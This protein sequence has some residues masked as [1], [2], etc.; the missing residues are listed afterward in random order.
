MMNTMRWERRG[1]G[2]GVQKSGSECGNTCFR[3]LAAAPARVP[4]ARFRPGHACL[5]WGA[6]MRARPGRVKDKDC[7]DASRPSWVF[8]IHFGSFSPPAS[9]Q[10]FVFRLF[11]S[12]ADDAHC[13]KRRLLFP[14]VF[15]FFV[16]LLHVRSEECGGGVIGPK[17]GGCDFPKY[18][19]ARPPLSIGPAFHSR[20]PFGACTHNRPF[21]VLQAWTGSPK[22]SKKRCLSIVV[23]FCFFSQVHGMKEFSVATIASNGAPGGAAGALKV[24]CP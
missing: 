3:S 1:G 7:A 24:L 6:R 12:S 18:T 16:C 5:P 20:T 10:P 8:S 21:G 17:I 23:L 19:L 13:N 2:R 14:V 15:V 11:F 22:P 9:S 4:A